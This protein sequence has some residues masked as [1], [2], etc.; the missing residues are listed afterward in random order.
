MHDAFEP[1]P[2]LEKLPL[3]ID[4]LAAWGEPRGLGSGRQR[5]LTPSYREARRLTL[6]VGCGRRLSERAD[7]TGPRAACVIAKDSPFVDAPRS[8]L[9]AM[10]LEAELTLLMCSVGAHF[11]S[12]EVLS[13]KGKACQVLHLVK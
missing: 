1:V 8:L 11:G 6:W 12:Q 10:Q 2:I 3:Q 4:C 13:E 7:V 9:C 5:P